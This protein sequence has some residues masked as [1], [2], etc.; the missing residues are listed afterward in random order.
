MLT[1]SERQ[2]VADRLLQAHRDRQPI[3]SPKETFPGMEIED[4]YHIQ[5]LCVDQWVAEGAQIKGYKVGLT[6]K[7]MQEA[8]GINEPDYG[9][10][11]DRFFIPE[12]ATI[13]HAAFFGPLV[14][15]ELAFVMKASLRGPHVNAADVIRATDFVLPAIELVDRRLAN[16]VGVVD[17][18]SD[19]ASCGA[20][21]LGGNPMRLAD[22]DIRQVTGSVI[23][24]GDMLAAG[25]AADVL[26]N[27]VNA[28]IWLANKLHEFG[29]TFEAGHVILTGSFVKLV[30]TAPGDHF[31]ARF[32][33]GFGDVLLAFA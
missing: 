6:S 11:L 21:I 32:D 15:I 23:K 16:R 31:I 30:P 28:V 22:L 14:E 19:L 4:A 29:V 13:P 33:H 7:A 25:S 5:Q 18:I 8:S 27:P 24:N 3:P 9:V 1:Q 2:T 12:A 17:T 20:V 10:L 26:G